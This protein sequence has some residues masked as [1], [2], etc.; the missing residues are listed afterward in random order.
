MVHVCASTLLIFFAIA[1]LDRGLAADLPASAALAACQ[2]LG[3]LKPPLLLG[4]PGSPQ[5]NNDTALSGLNAQ[6]NSTCSIEPRSPQELLSIFKII[7]ETRTPWAA[8]GNGHS[9]NKGFAST[10]GVQIALKQMNSFSY[11]AGRRTASFGPGNA[12]SDV[13]PKLEQHGVMTAGG[14]IEGVGVSGLATGGG[15]SYKTNQLGL[16]SDNIVEYELVTYTGEILNV[17]SSSHSDLFFGLQGGLNN[18]GI[19]T[20]FTLS[21]FPQS[22]VQGTVLIVPAANMTTLAHAI[23]NFSQHVVDTKADINPVFLYAGGTITGFVYL[24]YDG[25][26]IPQGIFDDFIALGAQFKQQTFSEYVI[27]SSEVVGTG[28][29]RQGLQQWATTGYSIDLLNKAIETTIKYGQIATT[30]HS[31]L[32]L[33]M[34]TE[35]FLPTSFSHGSDA[36][37][38]SAYP[39]SKSHPWNPANVGAAWDD[40]KDDKYFS[41]LLEQLASDM[42]AAAVAEGLSSSDAIWYPNYVLGDTPVKRMYG[43]NVDILAN[44]AKKWDPWRISSL[45]GGFRFAK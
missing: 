42:Q 7:N 38:P 35:W 3:T 8:K 11:D 22:L 44:I 10:T 20:K 1:G 5:F 36:G 12:W 30:N 16:V 43:D 45:T 23:L 19:V 4:L 32:A 40:P 28:L 14:R 15:Y 31:G 25:P 26:K 24:L 9:Y 13:F 33:Y 18:F 21:A 34:T 37:R 29:S 39:H 41:D 27:S 2:K 17:T 6:Q